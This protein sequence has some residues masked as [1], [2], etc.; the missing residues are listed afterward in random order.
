M[1]AAEPKAHGPSE[2]LEEVYDVG[3]SV[4]WTKKGVVPADCML[5]IVI[6]AIREQLAAAGVHLTPP[7]AKCI[8]VEEASM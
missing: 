7:V 2:G 4:T 5:K 1:A 3:A 6:P 8:L